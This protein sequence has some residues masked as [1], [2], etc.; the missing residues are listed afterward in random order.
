[1]RGKA[2]VTMGL[3]ATRRHKNE[4]DAPRANATG[5][6]ARKIVFSPD[7]IVT[8]VSAGGGLAAVIGDGF[9][10]GE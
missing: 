8:K 3:R 5:K 6:T 2:R 1:M 7:G 9:H 4:T 10:V